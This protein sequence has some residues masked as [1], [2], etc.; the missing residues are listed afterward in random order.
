MTRTLSKVS[1]AAAFTALAAPAILAGPA[2]ADISD[3]SVIGL[4]SAPSCTV[5]DGCTIIAGVEGDNKFSPVEFLING[6]S[7]GSANPAA[8]GGVVTA[9]IAWHPT[10]TGSYTIG[11]R[12]ALSMSTIVYVV[13]APSSLCSF[14]PS[15]SS[16]GSGGSGSASGSGG[17]GSA[18]SG[19]A[20][21]GSAGSGS[22][23]TGS[24]C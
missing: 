10:A 12:Q 6:N 23:G 20:G 24:A 11:V 9:S 14:L 7:I 13:G 18:G 17:S 15:G 16:S 22:A 4:G 2:G 5:A 8:V 3:I 19:S 1:A 21:S